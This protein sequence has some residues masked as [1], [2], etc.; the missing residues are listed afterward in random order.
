MSSK[1]FAK[2][3]A[4]GGIEI[5]SDS[6]GDTLS[7]FPNMFDKVMGVSMVDMT[8][9]SP[10]LVIYIG[11]QSLE[12]PFASRTNIRRAYEQTISILTKQKL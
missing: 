7:L 11:D 5:Q 9:D 3:V 4:H 12:V 1:V 10:V 6:H 2:Q 8:E